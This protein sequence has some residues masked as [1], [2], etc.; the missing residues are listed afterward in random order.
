MAPIVALFPESFFMNLFLLRSFSGIGITMGHYV[1]QIVPLAW[2]KK[3]SECKTSAIFE[4]NVY[5]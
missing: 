4:K 5:Q 3:R 1:R 2:Q